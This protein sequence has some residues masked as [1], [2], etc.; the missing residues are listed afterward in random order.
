ML[1]SRSKSMMVPAASH[2]SSRP[3]FSRH[4]SVASRRTSPSH[5]PPSLSRQSSAELASGINTV[6][7]KLSLAQIVDLSNEQ[8]S[9]Q[10]QIETLIAVGAS[11]P[12]LAD[13]A[14]NFDRCET[15]VQAEIY[16]TV[17]EVNKVI[18]GGSPTEHTYVEAGALGTI[19]EHHVSGAGPVQPRT[20]SY[21]HLSGTTTPVSTEEDLFGTTSS[22][23]TERPKPGVKTLEN[24]DAVLPGGSHQGYHPATV[25]DHDDSIA[26]EPN[27]RITP[28]SSSIVDYVGYTRD[29]STR[30][31]ATAEARTDSM[32][33]FFPNE[34]HLRLLHDGSTLS[35]S[36]PDPFKGTA[37]VSEASTVR[38][39]TEAETIDSQSW[40]SVQRGHSR[41]G[42]LATDSSVTGET[43]ETKD[44]AF[45]LPGQEEFLQAM[46]SSTAPDSGTMRTQPALAPQTYVQQTAVQ[47][48]LPMQ[49]ELHP[50]ATQTVQ[51]LFNRASSTFTPIQ[52]APVNAAQLQPGPSALGLVYLM[53]SGSSLPPT[54]PPHYYAYASGVQAFQATPM[55]PIT[56]LGG[57]TERHYPR[58]WPVEFMSYRFP[59]PPNHPTPTVPW[60]ET[61][62]TGLQAPQTTSAQQYY[63]AGSHGHYSPALGHAVPSMQPF[64]NGAQPVGQQTSAGQPINHGLTPV[65]A[66][67][68][69]HDSGMEGYEF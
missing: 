19:L 16:P 53:P 59:A 24:E 12:V 11:D 40:Q 3:P 65:V 61:T 4:H 28:S 7:S 68:R 21:R 50:A 9:F 60:Y 20:Y 58:S 31:T 33:T 56:I 30:S 51:P 23:A 46:A 32:A 66:N 18:V 48:T 25:A 57:Q 38:S 26:D 35:R 45:N 37:S 42:G 22:G 36:V 69:R 10:T 27:Q 43:I 14:K 54:N 39:Q 15:S 44:N 13:F 52:P 62:P 2:P 64:G 17:Q 6:L 47:S 67:N 5:S 49:Q 8:A 55:G 29:Q 1:H 34:Y 41:S 63:I